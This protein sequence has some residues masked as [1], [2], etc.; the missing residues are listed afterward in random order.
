MSV[1]SKKKT[2]ELLLTVAVAEAEVETAEAEAKSYQSWI[3][4]LLA[5]ML[6]KHPHVLH[7]HPLR[8]PPRAHALGWEKVVQT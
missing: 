4:L 3:M 8:S 6:S 7:P 2:P 5:R 1:N